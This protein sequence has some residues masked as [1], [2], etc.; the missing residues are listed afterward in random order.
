MDRQSVLGSKAKKGL[1]EGIDELANSVICTLGPN[2]RIVVYYDKINGKV[3]ATK[4]G[5]TVAKQVQP[6]GNL[7]KMGADMLREAALGTVDLAGDGTTTATLL[8]QILV[9]QGM[10][11]I[12]DGMNP[13]VL[14]RQM[15]EDLKEVVAMLESQSV[16]VNGDLDTIEAIATIS[17]NNDK[18]IGK[19]IRQAYEEVSTGGKVL[20]A[21]SIN[22]QTYCKTIKGMQFD[23]GYQSPYFVTDQDSKKYIRD[24]ARV[25]I[26]EGTVDLATFRLMAERLGTLDDTIIIADDF[27]K[28]AI[29][30]ALMLK[31]KGVN[32]CMVKAP[33]YKLKR[34][35]ALQDMCVQLGTQIFTKELLNRVERKYLGVCESAIISDKVTMLLNG[36]GNPDKIQQYVKT[37]DVARLEAES[38]GDKQKVERID[39]RIA[40]IT[41]GVATI[42]VGAMSEIEMK[43]KKD[44]IDDAT[45]AVKSALDNGTLPGGG[46]AL[47]RIALW[48]K[49]NVRETVLVTAIQSPFI[50]IA[51]NSGFEQPDI[52]RLVK[53]IEANENP[54]VGYNFVTGKKC[55]LREAGILDPAK[56]TI[57]ALKNAV[58]VAKIIVLTECALVEKGDRE[59]GLPEF[60]RA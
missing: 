18:E 20:V 25:L 45:E 41:T 46:I 58:S 38:T 30:Q 43:E 7:Q 47:L 22:D 6:V 37:L 16:N 28:P 56:V 35:E 49:K 27:E 2:G 39:G 3:H 26:Y 60:V 9:Q 32:P 31:G 57:S 15:E 36:L 1:Q 8:A 53:S 42:Y 50:Q 17:A 11:A 23:R 34:R 24:N 48:M 44:R 12:E 21:E 54:N 29:L 55:D 40:R 19:I 14:V 10:Q 51:I 4:D 52:I 59:E 5:V 33:Y 13:Q